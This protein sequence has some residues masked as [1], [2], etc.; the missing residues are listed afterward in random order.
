MRAE[1]L[2]SGVVLAL[3]SEGLERKAITRI[4][5]RFT[6]WAILRDAVFCPAPQD[7]ESDATLFRSALTKR[8]QIQLQLIGV[9]FFCG[10]IV[11]IGRPCGVLGLFL[12]FKKRL[13]RD[14]VSTA[15]FPDG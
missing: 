14:I 13:G 4:T 9:D 2:S 11:R 6:L 1:A 5:T 3:M 8:R 15:L 10:E 7:E 12:N